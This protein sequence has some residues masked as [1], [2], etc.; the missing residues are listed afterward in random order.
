MFLQRGGAAAALELGHPA[1]AA[2]CT[3]V[4][5][6]CTTSLPSSSPRQTSSAAARIYFAKIESLDAAATAGEQHQD[7][8]SGVSSFCFPVFPANGINK[9]RT[10]RVSTSSHIVSLVCTQRSN[11]PNLSSLFHHTISISTVLTQY[12]TN[13]LLS[14]V[15]FGRMSKK[16]REK[17]EEE[18]TFH[19][20][21]NRIRA[22]G[23]HTSPDPW[24]GPDSTIQTRPETE[25]PCSGYPSFPP[26]QYTPH[27]PGD[28]MT[29]VSNPTP[30]NTGGIPFEE[31]VD[32]TTPGN[33][34]TFDTPRNSLSGEPESPDFQSGI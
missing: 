26:Y 25:N 7:K 16:Q 19:Q 22:N 9:S 3:C 15:K 20:N 4:F 5:C 21:Q 18:V 33:P 24:T 32:S 14:A 2:S 12:V 8:S 23:G 34:P 30:T 1:A 31:Y 29:N 11:N 13:S 17:V 6:L 28:W 27:N 10:R